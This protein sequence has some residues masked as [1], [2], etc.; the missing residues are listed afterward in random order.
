MSKT[1]WT[2]AAFSGVSKLICLRISYPLRLQ[3][4]ELLTARQS[5]GLLKRRSR[6]PTAPYHKPKLP[7]L[8]APELMSYS[9]R[10]R[11][12]L[13][14]S[15]TAQSLCALFDSIE[16]NSRTAAESNSR[17]VEQP[18]KQRR[19][20]PV[21]SVPVAPARALRPAGPS[22]LK[23]AVCSQPAGGQLHR[24]VHTKIEDGVRVLRLPQLLRPGQLEAVLKST[25]NV[26]RKPIPSPLGAP[27]RVLGA[28]IAA[29]APALPATHRSSRCACR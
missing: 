19:V 18:R 16:S 10:S 7:T 1:R 22:L 2:R 23:T 14:N 4:H 13:A 20:G 21:P 15:D 8:T 29:L 28:R 11:K 27:Q 6:N 25:R 17:T 3:E 24:F 5:P 26:F 12:R 9:L